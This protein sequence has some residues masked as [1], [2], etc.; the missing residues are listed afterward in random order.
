MRRKPGI[1]GERPPFQYNEQVTDWDERYRRGDSDLEPLPLLRK[2]I[3]SLSPGRALDIACGAGRNA[4]FLAEHGWQ[5]TAVDAS[6][7]GIE[8]TMARALQCGVRVDARVANLERGE[9]VVLPATYDLICVCYYLQRDLFAQIRAGVPIGG[10]VVAA[11]HMVDDSLEA[12][13]MNPAFLL[14]P[15]E[16]RAEFSGWEISHEYEGSATER[17]HKRATSEIVARRLC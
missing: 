7:V 17:G 14:Q 2:V 6:R 8:L 1:R 4:I 16:L 5:V 15:G 3:E 10:M 11:I 9:F 13:P 12:Q